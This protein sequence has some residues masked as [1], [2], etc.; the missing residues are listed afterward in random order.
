MQ[1]ALHVQRRVI[2]TLVKLH[3]R[4][5]V[6]N[7]AILRYLEPTQWKCK[8]MVIPIDVEYKREYIDVYFS[9]PQPPHKYAVIASTCTVGPYSHWISTHTTESG[10][11]NIALE[12]NNGEYRE[13]CEVCN[14]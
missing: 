5:P 14:E 2:H 10:A 3:V 9:K 6:T 7:M 13:K 4:Q 11:K 8:Y 1:I 12:L